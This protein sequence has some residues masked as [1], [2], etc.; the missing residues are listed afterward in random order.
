L[1]EGLP[2]LTLLALAVD[3]GV[4]QE[5]FP[6]PSEYS[7]ANTGASDG[8]Y[9]KVNVPYEVTAQQEM[10][11]LWSIQNGQLVVHD[12]NGSALKMTDDQL[13]IY[14]APKAGNIMLPGTALPIMYVNGWNGQI[15]DPQNQLTPFGEEVTRAVYAKMGLET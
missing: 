8:W 4:P 1:R 12:P 11:G 6:D 5:L 13:Y 14:G 7:L 15:F 9:L 3:L 10:N 2:P